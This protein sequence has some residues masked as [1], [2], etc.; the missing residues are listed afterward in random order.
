MA[1]HCHRTTWLCSCLLALRHAG[2]HA[3][4]KVCRPQPIAH[5][6]IATDG[7]VRA[8]LQGNCVPVSWTP[9]V[10]VE[11]AGLA[12]KVLQRLINAVVAHEEDFRVS[13]D[14]ASQVCLEILDPALN[15]ELKAQCHWAMC[16]LLEEEPAGCKVQV[17]SAPA[18]WQPLSST[19]IMTA[20]YKLALAKYV[21]FVGPHAPISIQQWTALL[22]QLITL[23]LMFNEPAI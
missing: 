2:K 1:I 17:G 7:T 6:C 3:I 19:P 18:Q 11:H 21:D 10:K 15:P 13:A 23:H 22:D 16:L 14:A 8:T 9:L 20:I 12:C 4:G 5:Q